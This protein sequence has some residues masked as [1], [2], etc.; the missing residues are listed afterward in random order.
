MLV[1]QGLRPVFAGLAIGVVAAHDPTTIVGVA[2][3]LTVVAA[4]ACYLPARRV[5][6]ADLLRALRYE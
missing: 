2:V 4:I 6:A 1:V 5:T 3:L